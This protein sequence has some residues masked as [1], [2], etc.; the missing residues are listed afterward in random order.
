ML[1][2]FEQALKT[3]GQAHAQALDN[4]K[5][6]FI[7]ITHYIF[8]SVYTDLGQYELALEHH[9]K[10]LAIHKK[11][12]VKQHEATVVFGIATTHRYQKNYELA[13]HFFEQYI[14]ML[15]YTKTDDS[16]FYGYYGMA[17]SLS[18]QGNCTKA[19]P[20]LERGL[21]TNGPIDWTSELYNR[22]A[23]CKAVKGD[24]ANADKFLTTAKNI[25]KQLPAL[26]GSKWQINLLLIEAKIEKH[27][28][29]YEKALVLF[30]QYHEEIAFL[31]DKTY[32]SQLI[33]T[34]TTLENNKKDIEI[35]LL[36]ENANVKQLLAQRQSKE[37]QQQEQM[38]HATALGVIIVILFA[39][40]QR[41]SSKK[42]YK[43][44]ITDELTQLYNR[45]Y[46]FEYLEKLLT[47]AKSSKSEFAILV[48]DIDNFKLI[49]DNYGHPAGD[50]VIKQIAKLGKSL[51]RV[52]DTM[53]RTGGEEF[54]F[55]LPRT[56][57][58]DSTQIAEKIISRIAQHPFQLPNHKSI[59]ITASIGL[60]HGNHH[61]S[62]VKSL[63]HDADLALYES[64]K[65]G[66]NRYT[67]AQN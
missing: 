15:S 43:L 49:N 39:Y 14:N 5:L 48:M 35:K 38:I 40:I 62:D 36:K 64:K 2:D 60:S 65:N 12:K 4:N 16:K 6:F 63:Y 21:A 8:G 55:I 51:L 37:N 44:S 18:D 19:I 30:E 13:A 20:A 25:Y 22:L 29:N 28:K 10:A 7:G 26:T 11:L 57:I 47:N 24:F 33:K 1:G 56:S 32:S 58:T 9:Y 17:M 42:V 23:L 54:I 45:R 27:K 66:K 59:N 67:I 3:N 46:S 53:G 61:T 52:T 34:K 50:A 41:T 31:D